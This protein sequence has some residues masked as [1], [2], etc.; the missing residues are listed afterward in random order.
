LVLI[1]Y[2]LILAPALCSAY[3]IENLETDFY[4]FEKNLVVDTEIKFTEIIQELEW[5]VPEDAGT[6]SVYVDGSKANFTKINN[7][8]HI[9]MPPRD[10]LKISYVTSE[11]IEAENFLISFVAPTDIQNL[12]FSLIL[13]EEATLKKPIKE[14]T[15]TTGSIYPKPSSTTTDGRSLIFIWSKQ[16]MKKGD[17]L[18]IFASYKLKRGYA[19]IILVLMAL[20]IITAIAAILIYKKKPKIKEKIIK[21]DLIEKHLKED[22][23]I[24]VNILKKR[25]NKACEQGTIRIISGFSKATLSRLLKELEDRK[26]IKKEKRGKKNI[27][28]LK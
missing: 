24:I 7:K 28:F 23:E 12:K 10:N 17:E 1:L 3:T 4:I 2:F 5:V 27:I 25:E 8:L 11:F 9:A 22:E 18:S 6:I 15:I 14:D 21:E 26:V 20:L 19:F 16:D 13:P